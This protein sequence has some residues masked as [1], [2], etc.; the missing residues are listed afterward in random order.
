MDAQTCNPLR[1][2]TPG[3]YVPI[4]REELRLKNVSILENNVFDQLRFAPCVGGRV[5]REVNDEVAILNRCDVAVEGP[6]AVCAPNHLGPNGNAM[7]DAR[8]NFGPSGPRLF[9]SSPNR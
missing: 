2:H 7:D 5:R 4:P 3:K 9:R 8:A 6:F 1:V